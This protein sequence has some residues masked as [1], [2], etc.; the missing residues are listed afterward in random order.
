MKR[1]LFALVVLALLGT[2]AY[3]SVPDPSMSTV[4]PWDT[5]GKAV[6]VPDVNGAAGADID[7]TVNA[8]IGGVATPIEG[9]FVGVEFSAGCEVCICSNAGIEAYTDASGMATLNV[10]VGGCC[11][12]GAAVVVKAGDDTVVPPAL[13]II[14]SY[15][16][17]A[18]TDFNN[19]CATSLGDFTAFAGAY[20][21]CD[22]Q[23][24]DYTGDGC[25]TLGDFTFFAGNYNTGCTPAE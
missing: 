10:G 19:D 5:N 17:F 2:H 6:G 14:R 4:E 21:N 11:D 15:D 20:N 9:A 22:V 1:A 24:A 18:S 23:C 25:A 7:V 13:V 8:N 16:L 12:L 3:A